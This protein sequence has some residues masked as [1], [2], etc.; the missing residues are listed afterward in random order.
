MVKPGILEPLEEQG[1]V[2][3]AERLQVEPLR[4]EAA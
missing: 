4:L 1:G 2:R 3:F